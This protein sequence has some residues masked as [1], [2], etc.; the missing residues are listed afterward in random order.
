M[1]AEAQEHCGEPG[2]GRKPLRALQG[3]CG[4]PQPQGCAEGARPTQLRHAR[5]GEG[6]GSSNPEKA[7]PS[8]DQRPLH[9]PGTIHG[10]SPQDS[11]Y[12]HTHALFGGPFQEI[13]GPS[14][15][16]ELLRHSRLIC[17]GWETTPPPQP[18]HPRR[19]P[20]ITRL[21][22]KITGPKPVGQGKRNVG[23]INSRSSSKTRPWGR[24]REAQWV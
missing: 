13:L 8:G 3:G 24:G 23:N 5:E 9:E 20:G 14:R 19:N 12:M 16:Y 18:P 1:Q 21:L 4:G 6:R 7:R 10:S 17:F 2:G 22:P 15:I 11:A